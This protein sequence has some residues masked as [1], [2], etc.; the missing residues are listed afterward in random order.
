MARTGANITNKKT[1]RHRT[2]RNRCEHRLA[3]SRARLV[4]I[5]LTTPS[6]RIRIALVSIPRHANG[7][8]PHLQR[9]LCCVHFNLACSLGKMKLVIGFLLR[10]PPPHNGHIHRRAILSW[11]QRT[12]RCRK[13]P[14]SQPSRANLGVYACAGQVVLAPPL[15]RS[16]QRIAEGY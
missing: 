4:A 16:R 1:Q 13:T 6:R 10:C 2:R 7:H 5:A 14:A 9:P 8:N 3:A 15:R 12:R 11:S